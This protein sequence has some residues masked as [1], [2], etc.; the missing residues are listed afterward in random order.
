MSWSRF[1][2]ICRRTLAC[3][4]ADSTVKEHLN[5]VSTD[6][7]CDLYGPA[8]SDS[9]L[10]RKILISISNQ[11]NEQKA[12]QTLSLYASLNFGQQQDESMR[13]KRILAYLSYVTFV[14]YSVL[15]IY[16]VK[17]MPNFMSLFEIYEIPVP[18]YIQLLNNHWEAM[19]LAISIALFIAMFLAFKIKKLV[20]FQSYCKIPV[21]LRILLLPRIKRS[22]S[23][24]IELTLFPLQQNMADQQSAS[25][26]LREH[27]STLQG[28]G[29]DIT[30][31]VQELFDI[32][33]KK[34]YR[35]CEFQ[36]KIITAIIT[37][38]IITCIFLFLNSAYSPIFSLGEIV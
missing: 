7:S 13:I 3:D 29:V 11:K 8:F 6:S 34:L 10:Q 33:M 16:Q 1:S 20:Q 24:L 27:L 26:L 23:N 19:V 17:V 5:Q 32:E 35:H 12:H 15:V 37:M 18:G 28:T 14:F 38:T 30:K 4:T 22:Y 21:S 25:S 31:E 2:Y 9:S 36:M